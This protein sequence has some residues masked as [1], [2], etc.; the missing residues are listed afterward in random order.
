[1]TPPATDDPCDAD[2]RTRHAVAQRPRGSG[3]RR[4]G[5]GAWPRHPPRDRERGDLKTGREQERRAGPIAVAL[6]ADEVRERQREEAGPHEVGQHRRDEP[7]R[8]HVEQNGDEDEGQRSLAPGRHRDSLAASRR[9]NRRPEV[10]TRSSSSVGW[11]VDTKV[12]E[13]Y[14]AST[15]GPNRARNRASW[16]MSTGFGG[17]RGNTR[18]G[19]VCSSCSRS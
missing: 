2:S 9:R 14:S 5:G 3:G 12:A 19:R 4:R 18:R 7:E 6:R 13:P 16:N 8:E 10:D 11:R 1:M 15:T 17:E